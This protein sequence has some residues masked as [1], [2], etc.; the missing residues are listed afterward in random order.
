[1]ESDLTLKCGVETLAYNII[2]QVCVLVDGLYQLEVTVFG[3]NNPTGRCQDCI[4]EDDDI[5]GCCD[6]FENTRCSGSELCDS[7]F[8]YCLRTIGSTGRGCSYFGNQISGV[9]SDDG[10]LNFSQSTVLG[11]TNPIILQG[12]T[13]TYTVMS[14]VLVSLQYLVHG[15]LV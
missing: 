12:L 8:T 5:R 7:F 6:D 14:L 9:N 10:P 3:Y 11:L 13:N 4:E 1:M 15:M 2:M